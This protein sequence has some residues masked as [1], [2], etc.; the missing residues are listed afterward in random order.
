MIGLKVI[1]N[2][3]ESGDKS[4]RHGLGNSA[5]QTNGSLRHPLSYLVNWSIMVGK[6][7]AVPKHLRALYQLIRKYPGVSCASIVEMTTLDKRFEA[8][9][10][11]EE[12]VTEM[13]CELRSIVKSGNAPRVVA[14]A[15]TVHERM[16]SA[17][18]GDAFRYLVRSVELGEYMGI[19]EIQVELGRMSNSFQRKFNSRMENVATDFPEV[20]EIYNSWLR[21]RYINNPIVRLNLA[22]W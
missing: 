7:S 1:A 21:L 17:G 20:S 4:L 5:M 2:Q 18:L 8:E 19:R 15:L 11:N 13:M 6:R 22:E 9:M 12:K 3:D 16:A 14:R 10:R